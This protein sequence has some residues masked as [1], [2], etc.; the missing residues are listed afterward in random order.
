MVKKEELDGKRYRIT[1]TKGAYSA[2]I[3]TQG[4]ILNKFTLEGK[5]A[6]LGFDDWKAYVNA[7]SYMGQVVGPV[8]N[9]IEGASFSMDGCDY[10]LEKNNGENNLHSGSRN[11]GNENFEIV[12][13]SDDSVTLALLSSESAGFPGNHEVLVTY[14]LTEDGIL[15]IDYQVRSD[16]KCPVSITNH[17]YFNLNG[18]GD[19][20]SHKI[21]IDSSSYVDVKDDLI[22]TDVKESKGSDFDFTSFKEIGERRN[23]AYDHCFILNDEGK[24]VVESG[25]R[26]LTMRTTMPSVQ[27]YTGE[28]LSSDFSAYDNIPVCPF[29]GF[30]LESEYYPNFVNRKDF[31]GSYL[32]PNVTWKSTTSYALEKIV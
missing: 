15:T 31:L 2:S 30:C 27:L 29:M 14:F 12:G 26:R 25:D 13:S 23:G 8:A 3:L 9:R 4:A 10:V 6:V 24:V 22:P 21:K 20:R 16:K 17:T 7:P 5:N 1:I 19:I 32:V 28:F 18:G 11:Y